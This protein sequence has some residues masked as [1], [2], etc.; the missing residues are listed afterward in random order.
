VPTATRTVHRWQYHTN[1]DSLAPIHELIHQQESQEV[2]SKTHS[3]FN[4]PIW[5]VKKSDGGWRLTVD[6]HSLNEVK[7]PLSAAVPDM[8][9]LQ[10]E[11]E[12]KAAKWDA[13]IDIVNAFFSILLAAECRSQFVFI[14]RG[15]Q[16]T[17]NRLPRGWKHSPSICHGLIQTALEKGEFPQ[18][19]QYIDKIIVWGNTAEEVSVKGEKIIQTL[20]KASF[21]IKQSKVK[22]PAQEIQFLGIKCQDG[23]HQIPMDV[24]NKIAAMSPPTSKKEVQAFFCVVGF[25]RMNIPNYSQIVTPLYHLTGKK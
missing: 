3:L 9:E 1:Q 5:P 6:Y 2:I 22:G 13:T 10:Y 19:L 8:F 18:H 15:V 4:S 25:W 20:L 11:M 14:W 17:W 7:P 21:A 12:S 16:H 24:I 23:C